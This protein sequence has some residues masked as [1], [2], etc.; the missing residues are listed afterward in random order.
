MSCTING[1]ALHDQTN[2]I[3]EFAW[4]GIQRNQT[5]SVNGNLII[6]TAAKSGGRPMTLD[7]R[8]ASRATLTQLEAL[9]D[10]TTTTEFTLILPGSRSF[11]CSFAA[12]AEPIAAT[13]LQPRPEY[14]NE[15]LFEVILYLITT[16]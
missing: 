15:D 2:W 10:S 8:W 4:S 6:Q 9:R 1:I 13:P 12:V 14:E 3:D 7:C 16:V 5:R 11:T